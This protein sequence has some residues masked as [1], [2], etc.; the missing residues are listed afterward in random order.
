MKMTCAQILRK[1][2]STVAEDCRRRIPSIPADE[3]SLA[4]LSFCARELAHS[5]VLW[6][7]TLRDPSPKRAWGPET[8]AAIARA[9]REIELTGL[10]PAEIRE[11]IEQ[12]EGAAPSD[13]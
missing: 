3:A 5:R 9:F 2:L 10:K 4:L 7:A 12:Q 6:I 13:E 11:L 1:A 8:A